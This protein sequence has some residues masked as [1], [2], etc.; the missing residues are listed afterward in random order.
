VATI[1]FLAA[2]LFMGTLMHSNLVEMYRA[3]ELHI[4]R[5][6]QGLIQFDGESR[7]MDADI[8]VSVIKHA[9]HIIVP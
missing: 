5:E 7:M 6:R 9:V 1:P 8:S 2:E 3:A 4:I